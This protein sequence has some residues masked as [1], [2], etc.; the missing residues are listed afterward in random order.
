MPR[1]CKDC[2]ASITEVNAVP[3]TAAGKRGTRGT[4]RDCWNRRWSPVIAQHQGRYYHE[5]R[6]GLRDRRQA[7]ARAAHRANPEQT[8][9]RT[10]RYNERHPERA[11]ARTLLQTAVRSGRIARRPCAECGATKTDAHHDDYSRPLDVVWL[12]RT[13][14]GERHRLLNRGLLAPAARDRGAVARGGED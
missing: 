2:S 10:A 9:E 13:H 12:C 8:Y 1:S 4:C 11:A 6:N 14:H 3:Y 7:R 5:N